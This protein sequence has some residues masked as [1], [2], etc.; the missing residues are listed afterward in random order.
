MHL[1]VVSATSGAIQQVHLLQN[2]LASF[3][4]MADIVASAAERRNTLSVVLLVGS[5]PD[6]ALFHGVAVVPQLRESFVLTEE[7]HKGAACVS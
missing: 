5:G 4:P 6:M 3:V 1:S 7:A 2:F